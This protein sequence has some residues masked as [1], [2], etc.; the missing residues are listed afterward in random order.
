MTY[1]GNPPFLW[2]IL[3]LYIQP[4]FALLL[5][6]HLNGRSLVQGPDFGFEFS[7][8]REKQAAGLFD[9]MALPATGNSGNGGNSGK[10]GKSSHIVDDSGT[11]GEK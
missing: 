10:S 3:T 9:L 5:H 4:V 1:I 6:L 8:D 11:A 7:I 2:Y